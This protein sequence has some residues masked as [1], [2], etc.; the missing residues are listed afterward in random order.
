MYEGGIKKTV[1]RIKVV[2]RTGRTLKSELQASIESFQTEELWK[3]KRL[4][5]LHNC[6]ERNVWKAG[7]T[8][9]SVVRKCVQCTKLKQATD[10]HEEDNI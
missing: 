7:R 10:T 2:E 5:L 6:R 9:L 1:I 3:D 4:R 8:K